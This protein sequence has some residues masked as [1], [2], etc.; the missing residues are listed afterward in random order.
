MTCR[1]CGHSLYRVRWTRCRRSYVSVCD[2]PLN[3]PPSRPTRLPR[4]PP[5]PSMTAPNSSV[6]P[7]VSM[8]RSV[9]TT[10]AA[11]LS[12]PA[13]Y[14]RRPESSAAE[15]VTGRPARV[16]YTV[17]TRICCVFTYEH[18]GPASLLGHLDLIATINRGP[19]N[20]SLS[21]SRTNKQLKCKRKRV[22]CC[23]L[24]YPVSLLRT[25][26]GSATCNPFRASVKADC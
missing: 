4:G 23:C 16:R 7:P 22:Y 1:W 25:E 9:T 14:V 13:T 15:W 18:F 24:F 10:P 6:R 2:P 5:P 17:N 12:D 8:P 20:V 26:D 11:R 21:G 3:R 19:E